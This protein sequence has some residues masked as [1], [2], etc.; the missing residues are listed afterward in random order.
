MTSEGRKMDFILA[1]KSP[2]RKEI[3]QNLGIKFDVVTSG[4]NESYDESLSPSEVVEYLSR[5]KGEAVRDALE[6]EG[7]DLKNTIIIS[8]DTVVCASG[9]IL[10][11]PK[12]DADAERMLR[13]LSGTN[14]SVLSGITL[15]CGGKTVSASEEAKVKFAS[16]SE[17]DVKRYVETGEPRDKA[18]AYAIQGYASLFVESI[19]GTQTCVIGLPV[20]LLRRMLENSFGI[21]ILDYIK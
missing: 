20:A 9:E 12:D 8:A 10:G 15:I 21:S 6:K 11:K 19:L 1:S 18:G 4:A 5:I 16:L 14:H 2:R 3:L 7:K 17:G 13:M